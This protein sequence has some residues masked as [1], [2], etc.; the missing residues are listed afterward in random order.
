ML[1]ILLWM[2]FCHVVADY[3][4][5][6]FLATMKQKDYWQEESIKKGID[7]N[8]SIYKHDYKVALFMHSFAWS[9]MIMLPILIA[10]TY[11]INPVVFLGIFA[12][13]LVTHYIVDDLKANYKLINLCQDQCFHLIQIFVTWLAFTT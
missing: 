13:N 3:N 1:Y 2:I 4:L 11:T 12:I 6:G 8:N 9:F 5:Q 7:F 10:T